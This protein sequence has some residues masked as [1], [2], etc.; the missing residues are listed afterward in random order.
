MGSEDPAAVAGGFGA[1]VNDLW[2]REESFV[3]CVSSFA[4]LSHFS[5]EG[6]KKRRF[7]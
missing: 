2:G 3:E 1:T 7:R 5:D 4:D 6:P